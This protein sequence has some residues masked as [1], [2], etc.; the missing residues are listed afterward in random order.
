M[1]G[2]YGQIEKHRDTIIY[3]NKVTRTSLKM[4]VEFLKKD[5]TYT[6]YAKLQKYLNQNPPSEEEIEKVKQKFRR[7]P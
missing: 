6:T 2:L 7:E 4:I 3:L 1:Y 5:N